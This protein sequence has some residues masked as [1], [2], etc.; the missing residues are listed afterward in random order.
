MSGVESEAS[1]A[2]AE[3]ALRAGLFVEGEDE[4]PPVAPKF[5]LV[6][7]LGRGGAGVVWLARDTHLD[8]H[9]ALKLLGDVPPSL[10]ERFRR[11]ARFAARLEHPSIV[12]VWELDEHQGQ[13]YISME[14]VPGGNLADAQLGLEALARS[15]REVASALQHAHAHGIVHRDIKPE[16]I[17]L[18][19]DGR[20]LVAD[21]GIARDLSGS[22]G[23]TLSTAGQVMGTPAAMP[24]EQARG[25]THAVDAR[26]DVYA[27]GATLY[28]K[29]AGRWPFVGDNVVDVLHAVIHEPPP[30]LR[31]LR[32]DVPRA[33][34]AIA[35][36]CLEK[37]PDQRFAS[38]KELVEELDRF[39]QG[40]PVETEQGPWLRQLVRKV[41]G[42]RVPAPAPA[43]RTPDP[44]FS[45]G[46]DVARRLALWDANLYRISRDVTR[47][48]AALDAVA[49]QLAQ[50]LDKHPDHAWARF[51]R[52]MALARRDLLEL[53][54]DEMEASIDRVGTLA[55]AHFELGRV[56]LRIYLREVRRAR[57]HLSV[58]GRHDHMRGARARL[59]QAA[60]AFGEARRLDPELP[61]WQLRYADAVARLGEEDFDGCV[62][63]CDAILAEDP[64]ADEVW[65]LRGDAQRMAGRDPRASYQHALEIR[66]GFHQVCLVLAETE[67]ESG[68]LAAAKVALDRALQI[69]PGLREA[70]RLSALVELRRAREADDREA[71]QA[72]LERTAALLVDEP[73]PYALSILRVELQLEAARL[74]SDSSALDDAFV[75]IERAGELPGC[76]NRVMHLRARALLSRARLKLERGEDPDRELSEVEAYRT[77]NALHVPDAEPWLAVLAEA[78][79]L[80]QRAARAS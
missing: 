10:F 71:L 11:E 75:L 45:L 51:Q 29:L 20:A 43:P 1:R 5:D 50:H 17:L 65:K 32:H 33:L 56:Y 36:R 15:V 22:A 12:R 4:V 27:L 26:S 67:M 64:D 2:L 19:G 52:G 42:P 61:A 6:R 7:K 23:V 30:L 13:P 47:T 21:F 18:E 25:E 44:F 49:N 31:S 3:R 40:A 39:L 69:H 28:F 35:H 62:V 37:C 76:Q 34:E 53:A 41:R 60:L 63:E 14:Y 24:P 38:M 54:L 55:G 46:L 73:E 70:Q 66:R 72:G 80:R 68:D 74:D 16:N 48:H 9:V 57:G 79:E 8:R 59:E 58:T 77:H 78:D